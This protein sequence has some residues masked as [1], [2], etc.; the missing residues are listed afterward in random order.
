[1]N[2]RDFFNQKVESNK[3]RKLEALSKV[4]DPMHKCL[5]LLDEE[6]WKNMM[7]Y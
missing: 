2:V 4:E 6:D 1:M 7:R 3:L 5:T